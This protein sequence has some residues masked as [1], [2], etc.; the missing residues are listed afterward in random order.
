MNVLPPPLPFSPDWLLLAACELDWPVLPMT[1]VSAE[2]LAA[3]KART[4]AAAE[5][6]MSLRFITGVPFSQA[7]AWSC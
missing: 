1:V 4:A 6:V 5:T 2:A 3:P 7:D